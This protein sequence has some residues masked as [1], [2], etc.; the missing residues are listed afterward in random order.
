MNASFEVGV[1]ELD[2]VTV[3]GVSGELDYATAPRLRETFDGVISSGRTAVLVDLSDCT[4][5]DSTGLSVLVHARSR[6][7]DDARKGRLEVCCPDEQI[8]RLL[9]IT[10]IDK[11]FGVHTSR[12]D[13][14]SALAG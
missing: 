6:L 2:G 11:A 14:L 1:E 5:I 7:M 12:D 4:F 8:R 13:A 9:Q 3:V 10:G